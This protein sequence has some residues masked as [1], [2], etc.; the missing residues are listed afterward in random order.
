VASR[1]F[2]AELKRRNVYKVAVAYAV[3]AWL[4]IQAGS[5]LFPTFEAP[6]W[7]MKVFVAVVTAGFPIALVIAWAFEMTPQGMKRTGD[8]SPGEVIP[9]WSRRKFTALIIV[10]T[11]SAA[12]L[13][14]FQ[15]L[16]PKTSTVSPETTNVPSK[17]IAV[18]PFENLSRDPENAYFAD[19]IQD[20]ILSTV[21]KIGDLKVISR[22]STARYK[23]RPE[24][25]RQVG[26]EL[27]AATVL[28]GSVQKSEGRVRV[29]VQLIDA[30]S[31]AH[32]WSETYDRELKDI[33]SV[34]SE[35]A[36]NIA[37]ALKAKLS[38]S[39][40]H[41][42]GELPTRNP[43]AYQLYLKAGYYQ[44]EATSRNGDPAIV[45]PKAL[46]LYAEAIAKDPSFALAWAQTSYIHSWMHWFSV[47]D[48]PE[49][50]RLADEA[51][52]HAISLNSQ[53]GEAHIAVGYVAYWGRRDYATAMKEFE[54]ARTLLPNS[55]LVTFAI[56]AVHRRRGEWEAAVEQFSR[57]A[58]LDPRDAALRSDGAYAF[59]AA[60]RYAEASDTVEGSLTIQPDFWD[61]LCGAAMIA[62]TSNGDIAKANAMLA[63][64][65]AN[66]DPQGQV[67]YVRFKVAMWSRDFAKAASIL[68][69]APDFIRTDPGHRPVATATLRGEALEALGK[70]D[71]ARM[72]FEAA[73]PLLEERIKSGLGE[74]SLHSSLGR[75]Y[76]GLGQKDNALREGRKAVEL[77][78][79]SKDAF[80]GP[81]FLE[82]LAEIQARIGN[83]EEAISLL[84]QLLEMPAGF[85]LSP[86]LLRLDPAWDSLR[87]NSRFQKLCAENK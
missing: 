41:S 46:D 25:L 48:S 3:I 37:T 87:N 83:V 65:P 53:L 32:I 31:D 57:A 66:V 19:G 51:A 70:L 47:D 4:L 61:A 29:I 74:P 7:V 22:T 39:D 82:Q 30:A 17:S 1:N 16:R 78:P 59:A 44:R 42:L 67:T 71:K 28:E 36:Q 45:L 63:R 35:I 2:F 84:R 15:L 9:S 72:A 24:N 75:A 64:L 52:Q 10:L 18:L 5:I 20:E 6:G 27:G 58:S 60:R 85:V 80:D 69:G 76:A 33:F 56:A 77:L 43:E 21:A 49:R 14:C 62:I 55:A 50:V 79:V 86:A 11:I 40:A 34:Q 38:P 8:I 26:I 73:V 54:L 13:L 81:F 12:A 68:E 23:S